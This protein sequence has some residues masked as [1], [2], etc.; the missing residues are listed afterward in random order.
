MDKSADSKDDVKL[1]KYQAN[2]ESY[3]AEV[4][5]AQIE[6]INTMREKN[7]DVLNNIRMHRFILMDEAGQPKVDLRPEEAL[8]LREISSVQKRK[9][10]LGQSGVLKYLQ[11]FYENSWNHKISMSSK[12]VR[13]YVG[14]R[15]SVLKPVSQEPRKRSS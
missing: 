9:A 10:I 13:H 12:R 6:K 2:V 11:P 1:A 15:N 4:A 8:H 14:R 3:K 7:K 5:R